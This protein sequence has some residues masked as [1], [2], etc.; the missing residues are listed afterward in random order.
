MN[1]S[2]IN[3][4]TFKLKQSGTTTNIAAQVSYPDPNGPPF[5]AKL[6]PKDPL[7][8]GTTY[9]AVVTV[10]AKDLAGNRLDQD[11]TKA[12]SQQEAWSFTVSN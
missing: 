2:T 11:S 6:D 5:T 8:A 9:K 7:R 12:N 10:G 4:T 1:A 3:P